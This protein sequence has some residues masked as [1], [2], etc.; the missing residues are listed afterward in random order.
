MV[1]PD[2]KENLIIDTWH[3]TGLEE[4]LIHLKQ[5]YNMKALDK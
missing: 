5:V 1:H 2:H 3:K 4:K